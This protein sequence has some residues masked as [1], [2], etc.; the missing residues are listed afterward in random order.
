[1]LID[2]LNK[3][4]VLLLI[5]L[6]LV[7]ISIGV[8]LFCCPEKES[9][10]SFK[11]E[12]TNKYVKKPIDTSDW[13]E[14]VNNQLGFSIKIP[15]SVFAIGCE[16]DRMEPLRI[17][18]DNNA[19]YVLEDYYKYDNQGNCVK[20]SYSLE[21]IRKEFNEYSGEAYYSPYL[22]WRILIN[23]I[24]D[25]DDILKYV[26]E[27]FGSGCSIENK[28]LQDDGNYKIYLKGERNS[29]SDP[30][31][32]NC[33]LNF[34][35]RIIYSPQKHKLMSVVLGQECKFQSTNPELLDQSYECYDEEMI[36]TFKFK[37]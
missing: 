25:E 27:S 24:E 23:N 37:I 14:Y 12:E 28:K 26:K 30:W 13:N 18:Q 32:G 36:N 4:L 1:M 6:F 9:I 17:V 11:N 35:H 8:V 19:I 2:K 5:I 15:S 10:S 20:S 29:D 33:L 7:L 34:S 22:G 16:K 31:W 3:K 21:K